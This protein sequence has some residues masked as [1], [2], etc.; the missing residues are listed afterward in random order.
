MVRSPA[1]WKHLQ[2]KA[3]SMLELRSLHYQPA[4][5]AQP[6][7]RGLNLQLQVGKPALV[8]GRSGSGKSTLLS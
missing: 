6:V 2:T 5:A 7:L 1:N 3:P 4:T 8:A